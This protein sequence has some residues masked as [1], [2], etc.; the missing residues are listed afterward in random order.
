M[1]SFLKIN[2]SRI[3]DITLSFADIRK[4]CPVRDLYVP[5]VFFNAI[6]ENKILMKISE[7]TV[8]ISGSNMFIN[9]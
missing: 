9:T 6:R 7:F 8:F 1:R 3:G 4:S 2:P 5:N